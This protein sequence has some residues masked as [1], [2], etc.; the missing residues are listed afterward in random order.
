[1]H[2]RCYNP[3]DAS[4][5][6]YGARGIAVCAPWHAF[7]AFLV[8]MGPAPTGLS[9]DRED[10]ND[11]YCK[12][13]CRWATAKQQA[14]NKTNTRW[15]SYGG[16]TLSVTTWAE[17][18]GISVSALRTRLDKG[19]GVERALTTPSLA[20]PNVWRGPRHP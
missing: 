10:V 16:E 11:G 18:I 1:M 7:D 19:W 4:Y 14:R 13:N 20:S 17:R 15:V 6:Y 8:D 9:L 5:Q 2:A 3:R 12:S